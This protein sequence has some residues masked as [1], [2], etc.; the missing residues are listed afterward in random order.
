[1]QEYF[2]DQPRVIA[3]RLKKKAGL[4]A[5]ADVGALAT[6]I[7]KLRLQIESDLK[8]TVSD[9]TLASPHL[10]AL[11]Q[12]DVQDICENAGIKYI[13]PNNLFKPML[14]ET[15]SAYAGYGFGLCEHW[16]NETHCQQEEM[17]FEDMP[18]LSVHYSRRALTST[19][20]T[21]ATALGTWDPVDQRIENF[22]LGSDAKSSYS[23][24][25]EYWRA[26]KGAIVQRMVENPMLE[27]PRRIILTGDMVQGE[28]MQVLREVIK[29]YEG[30]V[31]PI[32]SEDA[33]VVAAKGA[34]ELRRRGQAPWQ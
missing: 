32:F 28:F 1:M 17:E 20:A 24:H 34:A 14:W 9:A 11:Y 23:S 31:P 21:I 15:S 5:S 16:E 33:V 26:V 4:P 19:L 6:V 27:K 10:V 2:D 29:D 8:I 30:Q 25:E 3:R 13:I 12:D 22:N 18:V 7:K